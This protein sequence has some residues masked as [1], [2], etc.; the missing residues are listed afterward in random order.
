MHSCDEANFYLVYCALAILVFLAN[1]CVEA[2]TNNLALKIDGP[3]SLGVAM[4]CRCFL[5]PIT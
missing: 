2:I 1:V 5:I 3:A 4:Q